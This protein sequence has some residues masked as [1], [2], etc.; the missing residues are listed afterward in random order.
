M[1]RAKNYYIINLLSDYLYAKF[2]SSFKTLATTEIF[3]AETGIKQN[4]L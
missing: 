1:G 4:I 3:A 2:I